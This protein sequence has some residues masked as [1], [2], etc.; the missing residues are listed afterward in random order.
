MNMEPP[1]EFD[2]SETLT[3]FAEPEQERYGLSDQVFF[4][5]INTCRAVENFSES[6]FMIDKVF[7]PP[8]LTPAGCWV[9]FVVVRRSG[10]TYR[11]R[12]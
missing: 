4:Y 8:G 1:R 2:P 11:K 9:E 10:S 6:S 7:G 5:M 3:L 12:G